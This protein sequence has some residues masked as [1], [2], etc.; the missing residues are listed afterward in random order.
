VTADA[1]GA[2][3]VEDD[4][5]VTVSFTFTARRYG[6]AFRATH[7]R[8]GLILLT[9]LSA[10]LLP[11]G[12]FGLATGVRGV[13]VTCTLI[14]ALTLAL[15]LNV[16]VFGPRQRHRTY[17]FDRG[18]STWVLTDDG[19]RIVHPSAAFTRPWSRYTGYRFTD[20]YLRL[21]RDNG[22]ADLAPLD[23]FDGEELRATRALLRDR[24]PQLESRGI[25]A[26]T[27]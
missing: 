27:P 15:L 2:G 22:P 26:A 5:I 20:Q 7:E 9:M 16:V 12:L 11:I 17:G 19:V 24:L 4:A 6:R 8:G 21:E 10:L 1:P 23:V 3:T 13:G 25:D 14:G 18:A